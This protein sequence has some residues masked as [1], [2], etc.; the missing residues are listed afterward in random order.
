MMNQQSQNLFMQQ[1]QMDSKF[2]YTDEELILRFQ[3]GDEQAWKPP[4]KWP[5]AQTRNVEERETVYLEIPSGIL[6][7]PQA[8]KIVGPL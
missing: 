6:S 2:Q 3:D 1:P 4:L 7:A 8:K 5:L